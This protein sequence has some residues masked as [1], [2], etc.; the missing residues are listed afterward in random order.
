MDV[1][2]SPPDES[3]GGVVKQEEGREDR[4]KMG[5]EASQ[6]ASSVASSLTG[7]QVSHRV[8][9]DW[10]GRFVVVESGIEDSSKF[11]RHSREDR[12]QDSSQVTSHR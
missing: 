4:V 11:D 8:E 7:E 5:R 10:V 6:H 1:C 12:R 9:K 2:G 3:C